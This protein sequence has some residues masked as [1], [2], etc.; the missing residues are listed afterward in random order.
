MFVGSYDK[1]GRPL[2]YPGG[3]GWVYL[4]SDFTFIR[5]MLGQ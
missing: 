4:K 1:D 2:Y 3:H 5:Y